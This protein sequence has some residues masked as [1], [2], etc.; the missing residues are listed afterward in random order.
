MS[1][2]FQQYVDY[3]ETTT[4]GAYSWE[5][6]EQDPIVPTSAPTPNQPASISPPTL[7]QPLQTPTSTEHQPQHHQQQLQIQPPSEPQQIQAVFEPPHTAYVEDRFQ[8][9]PSQF[10]FDNID[11]SHFLRQQGGSHVGRPNTGE[12]SS[13][14]PSLRVDVDEVRPSTSG[15]PPTAG[16]SRV[17]HGRPH[18]QVSHP[19]RR[20]ESSGMRSSPASGQSLRP[21]SSRRERASELHHIEPMP[22]MRVGVAHP[23]PAV[24]M[25]STTVSCPAISVWRVN[26]SN[27]NQIQ[28]NVSGGS[29]ATVATVT[30]TSPGAKV[31]T[32]GS[33]NTPNVQA[34][35]LPPAFQPQQQPADRPAQPVKR[36][37]IRTDA[38]FDIAN[39]LMTVMFELP[40]LKKSD[41]KI[42]MSFCPYS[43]LRQLTISGRTH[44]T[45]PDNGFSIKE[46]KFG[47]FSRTVVVPPDTKPADIDASMEDGILTLRIPGG[48]PAPREDVQDI[49]IR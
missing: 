8:I 40:G 15:S 5:G 13:R 37:H 36:Y 39:N 33:S 17:P 35:Q 43:H 16:P 38:H 48:T 46:R 3:S 34:V 20:P 28:R 31:P 22:Q 41:L 23:M 12:S 2:P 24:G 10:R 21:S 44:S 14:R 25:G 1:F 27:Q 18:V 26:Q 6:F 47:D 7:Q 32:P 9:Q 49:L 42:R 45:L 30:T 19:Y 29:A 11:E 4:P